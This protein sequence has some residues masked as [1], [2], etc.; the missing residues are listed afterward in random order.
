MHGPERE[1]SWRI[2]GSCHLRGETTETCEACYR[3]TEYTLV[4]ALKHLHAEGT[5]PAHEIPE[6]P[7][8]DP[9]TVWLQNSKMPEGHAAFRELTYHLEVFLDDL[10]TTLERLKELHLF[11]ARPGVGLD[12]PAEI[13][14]G[15]AQRD[16]ESNGEQNSG[17]NAGKSD[18]APESTRKNQANQ[19]SN[20]NR[21]LQISKQKSATPALPI[22][23]LR[24]FEN[25]MT[26]FAIQAR[27]IV[28]T[29][30]R[31]LNESSWGKREF[32]ARNAYVSV[33]KAVMEC[34]ERSK[35]DLLQ[36]I[37]A[38]GG[39]TVRLGAVGPEYI[40]G[41]IMANVQ[42][43]VFRSGVGSCDVPRKFIGLGG[44]L[45][46]GTRRRVV[47]WT[48]DPDMGNK[49]RE[50]S[51]RQK[52]TEMM[53]LDLIALYTEHARAISFSAT[54]HPQR[55]AFLAIRAFEEELRAIHRIYDT[56]WHTVVNYGKVT[57]SDS[58]PVSDEERRTRSLLESGLVVRNMRDR[59][60]DM[61]ELQ[62]MLDWMEEL[63][64][65]VIESI[66]VLDE[67]HG[68]AIRV[69]TLV[70]LFFLPL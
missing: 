52:D 34:L 1:Q 7:D 49:T 60:R 62:K 5:S 18:N 55:H 6:R 31:A 41:M 17:S 64:Q 66:E 29:N 44:E 67:G 57:R 27:A 38:E 39:K 21:E 16:G 69:F 63:R 26:L 4:D 30:R 35:Q 53:T 9:C 20:T 47:T 45:R 8:E 61:E 19:T 48:D 13:M 56:Q 65:R 10:K 40:V 36:S 58:F 46:R 32:K 2:R 23:L 33:L 3:G 22:S 25:I 12:T 15:S 11:I 14:N 28:L 54:M 37:A 50:L 68:K 43:G 51:D 70:T 59:R 24:S 42:P